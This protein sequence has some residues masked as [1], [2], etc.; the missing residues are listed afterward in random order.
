[1]YNILQCKII[2]ESKETVL[3]IQNSPTS[4]TS[5]TLI[6]FDLSFPVLPKYVLLNQIKTAKILMSV[7]ADVMVVV[8]GK[9]DMSNP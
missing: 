9:L 3:D 4:L 1:M 8:T 6:Q 5:A 7:D 2:S